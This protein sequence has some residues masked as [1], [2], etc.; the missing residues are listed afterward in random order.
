MATTQDV[1]QRQQQE[2]QQLYSR[3]DEVGQKLSRFSGSPWASGQQQPDLQTVE[4]LVTIREQSR[5][6]SDRVDSVLRRLQ[7]PGFS[8]SSPSPM[9][10]SIPPTAIAD[11]ADAVASTV[12]L[13]HDLVRWVQSQFEQN[14]QQQSRS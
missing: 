10:S 8:S 12:Y 4:D 14:S 9:S 11:L 13:Q 1:Q 6:A 2:A 7:Q 5:Y 3:I